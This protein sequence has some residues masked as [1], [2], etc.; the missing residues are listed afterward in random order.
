MGMWTRLRQNFIIKPLFYY[1]KKKLPPMSATE[2]EALLAGDVWM[3]S[4]LLQGRMQW[5]SL[6]KL[7]KPT[8]TAEEQDFLRGPVEKL[9]SLFQEWDCR[10]ESFD[11]PQN[12]WQY[13]K[14]ERFLGIIIPKSYGG[15]GFS[16]LAHSAIVQKIASHSLTAA[17]T[18]MV[19]NSLGPAELLI[20]YGTEDQKNYYLP[21]LASGD[22]IPC[23][24]LTSE[25]AGSDAGAMIDEGVICEEEF[26]GKK[27]IGIRLN[28]D[29]R[30]IT[31]APIASVL[32][33]AFKLYDP[34]KYLG[35][36]EYLGI[37]L[38]LITTNHPGVQTGLRH[39]PLNQPFMNGP[40]RGH[41]VFIPLEW[42]I[43]G[44][45]R[46][47]QG[48]RMLMECLSAG[49]GISLPALS[50][51]TAKVAYCTTGAY[52]R[53][54]RQFNVS[55][56]RFEG[57]QGAMAQ[58][59][60]YTYLME[61]MR[62]L[63]LTALDQNVHPAVVSAMSKYHM[64]EMA[65]QVINQAMDVHGGRGIMMGPNNYLAYA[66][67]SMPISI[68]VEGANLLTRHLMIFGQGAIRCH[69]YIQKTMEAFS[70]S[71][72]K[73]GI[74]CFE[75]VFCKHFRYS[76]SLLFR[77]IAHAFTGG[78]FCQTPKMAQWSYYYKQFDRLSI[79]LAWVSDASLAL[80][81]GRLKRLE[82]LSARLG[83]VLS[84]LYMGCALLKYHYDFGHEKEDIA[85]MQWGLQICLY[86]SQEA[87]YKFFN[88]FPNRFIGRFFKFFVFPYGKVYQYP[89]DALEH[90][91]ADQMMNTSA[92]RRRFLSD[93]FVGQAAVDPLA[94][95]E[96]ALALLIKVEPLLFII[97]QAIASGK[98]KK[99]L[100]FNEKIEQ[101]LAQGL[102]SAADVAQLSAY[103]KARLDAIRVD[104][105]KT[106]DAIHV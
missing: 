81:G 54:R 29:K 80:L 34:K 82:R 58:I 12:A 79:A 96:E 15:L 99:H 43:G 6:L 61:A 98:I 38:C 51:A 63:T 65:R 19:P 50:V 100:R 17:I 86:R 104:E 13:L 60:G 44:A 52:A 3:E 70:E 103:E 42:V 11:L 25:E 32:G 55:I 94:R 97:D 78:W 39:L 85:S 4:A 76:L 88:N 26:E 83:D 95:L 64:T 30:Y 10:Q 53:I 22:E 105:F 67:E 90:Q 75:A 31:L 24:A 106:R 59:A 48:W 89:S 72:V 45:E 18:A 91:L 27:I 23:F 35:E 49:R 101:A 47:G 14:N 71:D 40:T 93:C 87:F 16:A 77:N 2:R 74:E 57:V 69:P 56:G 73:V 102:L 8:L 62:L 66:Y 33:L 7:P 41:N 9:C 37:T 92:F 36:A 1:L 68:T 28:W 5:Q 21:R 46:I 20:K 84:Y